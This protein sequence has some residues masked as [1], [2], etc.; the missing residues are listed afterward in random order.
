MDRDNLRNIERWNYFG[1]EIWVFQMSTTRAPRP[2]VSTASLYRGT[3]ADPINGCL[4]RPYNAT[5]WN[6]ELPS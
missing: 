1:C 3:P 5:M 6:Q 2:E 4:M